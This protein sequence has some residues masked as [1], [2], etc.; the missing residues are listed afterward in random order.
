MDICPI[1][2]QGKKQKRCDRTGDEL[3]INHRKSVCNK[4]RI[5]ADQHRCVDAI[6]RRNA[7]DAISWA[8]RA[9]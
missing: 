3:G 9:H 5:A 2:S 1:T 6:I 4:A 7:K 8:P